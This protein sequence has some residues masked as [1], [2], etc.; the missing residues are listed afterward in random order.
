MAV[1]NVVFP[2]CPHCRLNSFFAFLNPKKPASESTSR[3]L[4]LNIGKQ[5]WPVFVI[6][7]SIFTPKIFDKSSSHTY[8]PILSGHIIFGNIPRSPPSLTL[9]DFP[10]TPIRVPAAIRQQRKFLSAYTMDKYWELSG[11][12][13]LIARTAV[14]TF[15]FIFAF[16][17]AGLYGADLSIFTKANQKGDSTMIFGEVLVVFSVV[18][19]AV[20]C[21]FTVTHVLWCFW[22]GILLIMWLAMT[23]QAGLA[24]GDQDTELAPGVL[25]SDTHAT[26]EFVINLISMLLWLATVMEA[27]AFCC[28]SRTITRKTHNRQFNADKDQGDELEAR[29]AVHN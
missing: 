2:Q 15:Q 11:F 7:Q 5:G 18:T 16:I 28:T 3:Q 14:R 21:I 29:S 23:A 25:L 12:H 26:S 8:L 17:A 22:D 13:G 19:C 20:H 1:E 10:G 27:L 4:D 9:S 24:F 6:R